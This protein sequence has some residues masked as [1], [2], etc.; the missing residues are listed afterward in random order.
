MKNESLKCPIDGSEATV[1]L[2]G[3]ICPFCVMHVIQQIDQLKPGEQCTFRVDDPLAVKAVPE[4][5]EEYPDC[6]YSVERENE[7]WVIHVQRR[8]D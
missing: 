4:E 2:Q 3:K 6:E 7:S 1:D 5:M 8:K